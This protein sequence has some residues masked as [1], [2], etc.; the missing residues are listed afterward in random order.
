MSY[1]FSH[2]YDTLNDD[3]ILQLRA[4]FGME[5]YG[6]FWACLETM[7]KNEDGRLKATLIGGLSINYGVAKARLSE[8]LAACVEVGLFK[9]DDVGFYSRRMMEHKER[10]NLLSVSGKAGAKKRW[11]NSPPIAPP[12]AP[13]MHIKE[14][15]IK[16]D[17]IKPDSDVVQSTPTP[18]EEAID[19]FKSSLKQDQCIDFLVAKGTTRD[20]AATEIDKFVS[21]WTEPSKS[22]KKQRWQL[23]KTFE[24]RRRL[25]T[26]LAN[27][28]KRSGF[29]GGPKNNV[30]I[31]S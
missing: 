6:L 16:E 14:D 3:K 29:G 5:G 27:L 15:K 21:Y 2:D 22:G 11:E 8:F 1:F 23:E 28:N 20:V 9:Q 13:P 7:A 12:I 26:W 24:V 25:V 17:K 10:I 19:F 18:A 31:I 4:E 30:L